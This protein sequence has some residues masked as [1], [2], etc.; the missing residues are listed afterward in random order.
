MK[1]LITI[2][3]F[4]CM[5]GTAEARSIIYSI[6]MMVNKEISAGGSYVSSKVIDLNKYNAS[7]HFSGQI[8][9]STGGTYKFEVL[10][11]ADN[12]IFRTVDG[13]S[14]IKTGITT[15]SGPQSDGHLFVPFNVGGPATYITIKATETGGSASG[16][17]TFIIEIASER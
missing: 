16:K 3:I 5:V 10:A 6:P 17:V 14:P 8:T 15:T 2:L 13:Q 1:K 4:L 9:V 12:S 7:G 11:S